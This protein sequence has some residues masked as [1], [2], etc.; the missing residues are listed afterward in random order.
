MKADSQAPLL[1]LKGVTKRFGGLVAL[2]E[3]VVFTDA[4]VR[5]SD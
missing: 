4:G 5:S 3:V 2:N 1:E